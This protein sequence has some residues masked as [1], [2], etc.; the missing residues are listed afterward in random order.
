[1]FKLL[2]NIQGYT[3]NGYAGNHLMALAPT[4]AVGLAG[5][6]QDTGVV[7]ATLQYF[8]PEVWGQSIQ[9]YMEKNLVFGSLCQDLSGMVAGGGDLIHLPKHTE[10]TASDTYGGASTA[11]ETLLDT[12]LAFDDSTAQEDQYT[13]SV[14]QGIHTAISITDVAKMQAS[15]D[16][17]NIYTSKMGYA[18]AKK[19]DQYV[20]LQ[21]FE[22]IAFNHTHTTGD[23]NG[24][25]NTIELNTTHDSYDIIVAGVSNMMEAIHANDTNI[26]DWTMI[27][28][29]KCYASLF[30]LGDFARYDGIG[31][32]F[33]TEVPFISG[34]AGKLGGVNVVVSTNFAHYDAGAATITS[35]STPIGNF[36]ANGVTDESEKLLGLLVHKDAAYVAYASGMKARVQSDYHLPT[37]STRFVAD[38]VFGSS[39]TGNATNGNKRVF[40]LVSPAS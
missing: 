24:A 21:L 25:G 28:T 5:G 29:P 26:E 11:V 30:K 34:F 33:G 7:D 37:L 35:S 9:D 4:N 23:G 16:V 10:L 12:N 38:S 20:S 22:H 15:Y 40:A 19:I 3:Q 13:L 18:L 1:M 17:M 6:L 31:S 2:N 8:I 39:V 27:L 14:N 32:S 36:S